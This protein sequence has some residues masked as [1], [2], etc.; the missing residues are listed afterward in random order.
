MAGLSRLVW[1]LVFRRGCFYLRPDF[2][3]NRL[4]LCQDRSDYRPGVPKAHSFFSCQRCSSGISS[5]APKSVRKTMLKHTFSPLLLEQNRF[6]LGQS[7][8]VRVSRF[9][10]GSRLTRLV[11]GFQTAA[12]IGE[13]S[14]EISLVIMLTTHLPEKPTEHRSKRSQYVVAT[15]TT[16]ADDL[17]DDD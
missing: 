7:T 15:R 3:R 4:P 13:S 6:P 12:A 10:G 2:V 5:N 9:T 17:V 11:Q 16:D 14:E 8:W 1:L